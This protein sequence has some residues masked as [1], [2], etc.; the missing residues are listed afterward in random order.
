V[1]TVHPVTRDPGD[2]PLVIP[3]TLG[4]ANPDT[5]PESVRLYAL[6]AGASPRWAKPRARVAETAIREAGR[7]WEGDRYLVVQVGDRFVDDQ[8]LADLGEQIRALL[9]EETP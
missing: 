4:W 1:E 9:T 5:G 8:R 7:P 2:P 6:D 3:C